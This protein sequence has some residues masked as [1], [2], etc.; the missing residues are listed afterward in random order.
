MVCIL[1]PVMACGSNDGN[2]SVLT[3]LDHFATKESRSLKE[4]KGDKGNERET[5]LLLL[6]LHLFSHCWSPE[7]GSQLLSLQAC[8]QSPG[9]SS[10]PCSDISWAPSHSF[11]TQLL[12]SR[13][14][15][16]SYYKNWLQ[17]FRRGTNL[18]PTKVFWFVTII[19]Q[20]QIS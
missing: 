17:Q 15:V 12:G 6:S 7:G 5:T 4:K 1:G 14:A 20:I 18:E 11:T 19:L 16:I 9:F 2:I 10:S 3:K 13:T 8:Q